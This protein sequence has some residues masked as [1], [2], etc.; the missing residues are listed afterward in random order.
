MQSITKGQHQRMDKKQSSKP[1]ACLYCTDFRI[2]EITPAN[3]LYF[4][5]EELQGYVGGRIEILHLVGDEL[6]D[7]LLVVH[8][9]GKL[10]SLPF[11]VPAT[12]I[13]IMYYGETDF[14]A[15]DALICHPNFIR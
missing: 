6:E 5:L 15:G 9:E 1:K 12:L 13:W 7:R 2:K 11:N 14:V 8:E 4:T 10:I 3:G